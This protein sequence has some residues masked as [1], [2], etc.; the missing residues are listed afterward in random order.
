M[1]K[2]E[3]FLYLVQNDLMMRFHIAGHQDPGVYTG[4]LADAVRASYQ[5][6]DDVNSIDA[7]YVFMEKF[8]WGDNAEESAKERGEFPAWLSGLGELDNGA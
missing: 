5:I 6:P 2:R 1:S 4:V 7:A 8:Y 3:N